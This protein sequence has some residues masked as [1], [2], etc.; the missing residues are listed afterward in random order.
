MKFS[1]LFFFVLVSCQTAKKP[2]ETTA[3]ELFLKADK[4]SQRGYYL[5]AI[6]TLSKLKHFYPYSELGPR[7]DLLK[8]DMAFKQSEWKQAEKSY[9]DFQA[10]YPLHKD[11]EYAHFQQ[12]L[13]LDHQIPQA[14][15]RDI[16]S[17]D[18]I[19]KVISSFE[20]MFSKS[21]YKEQVLEIKN[22]IYNRQAEKE[23]K[24][25][26]FYLKKKKYQSALSRL[27]RVFEN[28]KNSDWIQVS[29]QMGVKI[30]E[31]LKDEDL[32]K[33]YSQRYKN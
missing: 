32:K 10:L 8:A 2:E 24:I 21:K 3:Q 33:K 1:L 23:F 7:A 14:A 20:K 27:E 17:S 16:S 5:E 13:S 9:Q 31:I 29:A 26:S 4:Q 25:A 12:I 22:K 19:L 6:E 15:S 18:Q 11:K 28:Y 30:A